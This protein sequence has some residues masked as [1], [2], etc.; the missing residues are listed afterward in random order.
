[1]LYL[2]VRVTTA[3]RTEVVESLLRDQVLDWTLNSVVLVSAVV[4]TCLVLGVAIAWLLTSTD[5]PLRGPL[6]VLSAL[7]LAVPSYVAAFGWL[8]TTPTLA[9]FW[10][11]WAILSATCVPYVVLPTAAAL[12]SADATLVEVAR[13]HGRRPFAAW[14][15]GLL[16]QVLPAA[17]AGALLAGLYTLADFGTPALMRH[18]V[19][20]FAI[21]RSYGSFVSRDRAV[22][23]AM[24][25][26]VAA[27]VLVLLE[28]GARGNARRWSVS[29]GSPRA[30]VPARL[31]PARLPALVL[32]LAPVVVAVVVPVVA[33]FRRLALGTR[34]RLD[35]EELADAAVA[36]LTVGLVGGLVAMLLASC[37][38]VLAARHS[39]RGVA[40]LETGAFAGHALPGIVVGLSLVYF[41][42]RVVPALYQSLAILVFAYAVLFM[43]KAIGAI[44]TSV[45]AVPPRIG[46][47]AASLG[48][49]RVR[50]GLVTGRIAAPGITAGF[51]LVVVT[52]MKELPATLLLR[53]SGFDTLATEMWSRNAGA[54]QGAAAP[55]ALVLVLMACVPSFLLTRSK[56]WGSR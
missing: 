23:L 26:V 10:P 29:S 9:G 47:V 31:G 13:S 49:G 11:T 33:L 15:T 5:L 50:V 42:L 12:R 51:L 41:S 21:E 14:R 53:P 6:L 34:T 55:Y 39:G 56:G 36:T 4:S 20:T 45:A 52:V 32:V 3:G 24:A 35:L 40:L 30:L 22:V 17:A 7:P 16:P 27:V 44:R 37:V 8:T 38:G 2:V 48:R 28:R 25:L 43:P 1:M 46:E 54:A 19:L 18:H